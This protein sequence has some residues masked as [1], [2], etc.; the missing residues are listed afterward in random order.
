MG[1]RIQGINESA[2]QYG[3]SLMEMAQKLF[4]S[5]ETATL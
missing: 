2:S 4:K 3:K 5:E 1:E